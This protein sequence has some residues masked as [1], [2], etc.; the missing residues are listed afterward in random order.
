MEIIIGILGAGI[1]SGIM[2]VILAYLN[3]KWAKEDKHDTRLDVII[4]SQK[5]IVRDRVNYIGKK[6][7][8]DG[9]IS[10]NDKDNLK[11]MYSCYRSLGGN[12]HLDTIMNE[13]DKLKVIGERKGG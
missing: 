9:V 4:N 12:G 6:Y 3:H 13:I 1:G 10:L 5:I 7:I 2:A 8:I 11:E